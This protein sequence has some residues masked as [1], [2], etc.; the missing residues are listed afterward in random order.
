MSTGQP[1]VG[2]LA[3]QGDF[4]ERLM[5]VNLPRMTREK[6]RTERDIDAWIAE[7]VK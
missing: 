3:L 5:A 4:A 7:Q 1:V 6:R 2:V